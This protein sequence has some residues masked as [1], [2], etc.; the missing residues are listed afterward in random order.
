MSGQNCL[1]FYNLH[2]VFQS[3]L[4]SLSCSCPEAL[5]EDY[6]SFLSVLSDFRLLTLLSNC[7]S[8]LNPF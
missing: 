6:V 3:L 1:F 7:T 4:Q 2:N 8:S 5:V